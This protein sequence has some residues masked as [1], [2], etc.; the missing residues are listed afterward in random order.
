MNRAEV[1][2]PLA[3][4]DRMATD[5]GTVR[6]QAA[7]DAKRTR[8]LAGMVSA[9][10]AKGYASVTVAD[11]VAAAKVSRSTFYE[12]FSGLAECYLAAYDACLHDLSSSLLTPSRSLRQAISDY[13]KALAGAPAAA[14]TCM[15]EVY[16][17]GP[18]AVRRRIAHQQVFVDAYE[19][20][21]R[22]LARRGEPVRPL[23][24]FD[25]EAIVTTVSA[26]VTNEVAIGNTAGLEA[27]TDPLVGFIRGCFGLDVHPVHPD[28]NKENIR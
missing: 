14:R 22:E 19:A 16:A 26:T 23:T 3:L 24:R 28:S 25:F 4:S 9:T 12:Q 7:L 10:A 8:V 1:M 21:H 15:V 18:E 11:V 20:M 6:R 2:T 17:V 5:A 27:L 13:L